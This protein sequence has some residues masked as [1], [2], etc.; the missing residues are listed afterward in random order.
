M[1]LYLKY[2]EQLK[3]FV[4]RVWKDESAQGTAEYVL[5][6]VVIVVLVTIFRNQIKQ[7]LS[8]KMGELSGSISSFTGE[9]GN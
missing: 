1:T 7:A 2:L 8:D 5:L 9:G 6:I 4:G 3:G